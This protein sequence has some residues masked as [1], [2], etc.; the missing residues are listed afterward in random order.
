V[1]ISKVIL[2]LSLRLDKNFS[3]SIHILFDNWVKNS[4]LLGSFRTS[5]GVKPL[6]SSTV[7]SSVVATK[8][9][10]FVFVDLS[11]L[12]VVIDEKCCLNPLKL[13]CFPNF[14]LKTLKGSDCVPVLLVTTAI[15][16]FFK[17]FFS[18]PDVKQ[19]PCLRWWWCSC[20]QNDRILN[21]YCYKYCTRQGQIVGYLSSVYLK[22]HFIPR[23]FCLA[24]SLENISS[25]PKWTDSSDLFVDKITCS[26]PSLAKCN[27]SF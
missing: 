4:F 6:F 11:W 19:S 22:I 9:A 13:V 24:T 25:D 3:F 17:S 16:V 10:L 15:L 23:R 1:C 20:W 12:I 18:Q 27:L 2:S 7:S 14:C 21:I 5:E 8:L 26:H